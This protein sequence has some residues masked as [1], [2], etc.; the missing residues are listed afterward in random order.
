MKKSAR[1]AFFIFAA[2]V[3]SFLL[4]SCD[5]LTPGTQVSVNDPFESA[6]FVNTE[7]SYGDNFNEYIF[8]FDSLNKTLE[9]IDFVNY[10]D[11]E[12]PTVHHQKETYRT[13][14]NYKCYT[15]T[16]N[17]ELTI[18]KK[19]VPDDLDAYVTAV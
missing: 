7:E 11:P 12:D 19:Y 13:L 15:G 8:K 5:D 6:T 4:L 3:S 2:L 1:S 14:Y 10:A 9:T 17:L 16:K 18:A